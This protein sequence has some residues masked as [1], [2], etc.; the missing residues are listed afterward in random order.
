MSAFKFRSMSAFKFRSMSAFK[1]SCCD[2]STCAVRLVFL[3]V[4]RKKSCKSYFVRKSV[5]VSI[6]ENCLNSFLK[7]A[8]TKVH[9]TFPYSLKLQP[10][11]PIFCGCCTNK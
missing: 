4:V 11:T 7:A 10:L 5:N 3:S 9:G 2:T 8:G 6:P 1:N